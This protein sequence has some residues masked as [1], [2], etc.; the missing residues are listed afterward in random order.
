MTQHRDPVGATRRGFLARAAG[1]AAATGTALVT[2]AGTR[3]FA[4][5]DDPA[6]PPPTA[7][8]E[9]FW[10]SNQSGIVT[11]AQGHTYFAAL[12]LTTEK[13]GDVVELL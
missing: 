8:I 10:G 13:R 9:P 2:D 1:L 4:K 11:P 6:A 5:A 3:V 7:R 12:D